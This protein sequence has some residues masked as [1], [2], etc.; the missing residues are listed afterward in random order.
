MFTCRAAPWIPGIA[1]LATSGCAVPWSGAEG[2]QH[3]VVV[4]VGVCSVPSM[5]A[6][7]PVTAV[8]IQAVGL[9]ASAAPSLRLVVGYTKSYQ[10][11]AAADARSVL[12]E[13]SDSLAG[14]LTIRTE[15]P[16]S[17]ESDQ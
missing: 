9:V 10:M 11:E 2:T 3:F 5:P 1:A 4:G 15:I 14:P 12:L 7:V 13:M 8:K 16:D 6:D 17:Q